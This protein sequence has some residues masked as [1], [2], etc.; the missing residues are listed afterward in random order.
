MTVSILVVLYTVS[1]A[2]GGYSI[3]LKIAVLA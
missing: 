2:I 3:A 1:T